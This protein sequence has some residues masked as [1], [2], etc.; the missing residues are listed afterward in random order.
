MLC[1]GIFDSNNLNYSAAYS[2]HWGANQAAKSLVK[3]ETERFWV[4]RGLE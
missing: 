3:S 2:H 4:Y 1:Y